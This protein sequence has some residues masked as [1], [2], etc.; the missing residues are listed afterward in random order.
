DPRT[1][2]R[3]VGRHVV[4]VVDA[5]QGRVLL[6]ATG[7][8]ARTLQVVALAQREAS[9][10]AERDV[11]VLRGGEVGARPQEAVALVAQVEQALD[12]DG[13]ALVLLLLAAAL[14]LTL[15]AAVAVASPSASTPAV[16]R[17]RLVALT[18]ATLAAL[19]P[20]RA[21]VPLAAPASA[22]VP[23]FA[24]AVAGPHVAAGLRAAGFGA[25]GRL[26]GALVRGGR[27]VE[28]RRCGRGGRCRRGATVAGT[29]VT[30]VAVVT[31]VTAGRRLDLDLRVTLAVR[32]GRLARA[33]GLLVGRLDAR[34][35]QDVVDEGRLRG[36]R[37]RLH[38]HG[39]GD[40][41]QLFT[42]LSLQDRTL[43]RL[44]LAAHRV[45]L[46]VCRKRS[47]PAVCW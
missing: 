24:L 9:H 2:A 3:V 13:L 30:H 7:G 40:R 16:A 32:G 39:A 27:A 38:A 15:A 47:E 25:G 42:F 33:L 29:A 31:D 46:S 18:T 6:V 21:L 20:L 1:Q 17:L 10:L 35:P 26:V 4:D 11:D 36:A 14:E 5:Q 41:L 23:R 44:W 43:E 19:V 8:S 37:G 12:L 34:L 45:P 28:S 22:V